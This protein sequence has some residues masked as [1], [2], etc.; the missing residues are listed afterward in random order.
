MRTTNKLVIEKLQQHI[1][2][3]FEHRALEDGDQLLTAEGALFE[4]LY[5]MRYGTRTIYQTALDWVEGGGLLI[6]HGDVKDFLNSLGINPT[7]Q[8]YSDDKSWHL[9]CHL[10]AR[11]MTKLYE[12]NK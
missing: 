7:H 4:Q 6:Y 12:G 9:Y 10:V 8:E 5:H 11:E 3:E 1:I 2:D